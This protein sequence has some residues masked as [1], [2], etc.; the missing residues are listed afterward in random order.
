MP[1]IVC[2]DDGKSDP[3]YDTVNGCND[4]PLALEVIR[5]LLNG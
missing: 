1:I 2:T 4:T 5:L 3:G